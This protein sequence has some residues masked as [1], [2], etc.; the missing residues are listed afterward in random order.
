MSSEAS[1]LISLVTVVALGSAAAYWANRPQPLVRFYDTNLTAHKLPCLSLRTQPYTP[2]Y[3]TL[4]KQ[5]YRFD[6]QCPYRVT[7]R[8]KGGIVCNSTYNVP[9]KCVEGM[10]HA[11]LR[12]DVQRGFK[13]LYSYYVDVD[14]KVDEDTIRE[15][16]KRVKKDVV[17][18]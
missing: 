11:F 3:E 16:W 9:Q 13:T 6:A 15:G 10:P 12:F 1:L 5:T 7:L 8:Y 14:G 2:S 4:L 17:G 18:D